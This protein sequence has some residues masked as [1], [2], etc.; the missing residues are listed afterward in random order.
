MS[1]KKPVMTDPVERLQIKEA[2]AAFLEITGKTV[3]KQSIVIEGTIK[4]R[5]AYINP[6]D[7][8]HHYEET[9]PFSHLVKTRLL[10]G[11]HSRLQIE[12]NRRTS[13]IE[14]SLCRPN[15][16]LKKIEISMILSFFINIR[17]DGRTIDTLEE[18]TLITTPLAL[19][20]PKER[21]PEERRERWLR[22]VS[23]KKDL[24]IEKKETKR[25][26]SVEELIGTMK[27]GSNQRL[28]NQWKTEVRRE[29]ERECKE[30]LKRE[31]R[32][33]LPSLKESILEEM[34]SRQKSL[35]REKRERIQKKSL[36]QSKSGYR[37]RENHL[38]PLNR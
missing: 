10:Y 13:K 27:A 32:D 35:E 3:D 16:S 33:I 28:L 25:E 9:I 6:E 31:I 14:Y 23:P 8:I 30:E 17:E 38:I 34:E 2:Q 22:R 18:R 7:I 20:I 26:E 29:L 19:Q 5:V 36:K 4:C 15:T 12:V 37:A 11:S 21:L 1:L 24:L